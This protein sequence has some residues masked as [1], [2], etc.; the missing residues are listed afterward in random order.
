MCVVNMRK[1]AGVFAYLVSVRAQADV[2]YASP[3]SSG[4]GRSVQ[5][6]DGGLLEQLTA[7]PGRE[8]CP[9]IS[10]VDVFDVDRF[11]L[12]FGVGYILTRGG[13]RL[14]GAILPFFEVPSRFAIC[15]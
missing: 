13:G 7:A 2:R 3:V 12:R 5:V 15:F 9:G 8:R 4:R 6:R 14:G 11:L 1:R 10:M